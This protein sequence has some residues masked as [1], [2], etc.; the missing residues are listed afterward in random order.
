MCFAD[1]ESRLTLSNEPVAI[2]IGVH[3]KENFTPKIWGPP[4]DLNPHFSKQQCA[5][6]RKGGRLWPQFDDFFVWTRGI[7]CLEVTPRYRGLFSRVST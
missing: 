5:R 7:P 6:L 3:T 1:L 4:S 2:A